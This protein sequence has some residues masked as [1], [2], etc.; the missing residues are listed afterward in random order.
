V[1]GSAQIEGAARPRRPL[2]SRRVS[3]V[4]FAVILFAFALPFGTVSCEGPAVKFTGYQLATWQV[5]ETAPPATTDDGANLKDA[6]EHRASFWA[7]LTLGA[8]VAG[9]LLGIAGRRGGGIAASVGLAGVLMLFGATEPLSLGG[10]D[11]KFE[12][13]FALTAF[14]YCVLALWHAIVSIRRRVGSGA[15]DSAV[16][17]HDAASVR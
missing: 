11:V 8:A 9:G 17:R 3:P 13:G 2:V 10:P 1:N 12:G 7:L 5:P 6:V 16:T 15:L 14:L 4:L